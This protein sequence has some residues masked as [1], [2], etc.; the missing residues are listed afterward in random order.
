MDVL[1]LF[2]EQAVKFFIA[3]YELHSPSSEGS[4]ELVIVNEM[5]QKRK[6]VGAFFKEAF[7]IK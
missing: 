3:G 1:S 7:V 6:L 2:F 4:V 5:P